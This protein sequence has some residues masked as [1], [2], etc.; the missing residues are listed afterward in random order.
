MKPLLD[1]LMNVVSDLGFSHLILSG[2]PVRGQKLDQLVELNG[3]PQEWYA[4]YL[5]RDYA[6]VDAVCAYSAVSP[7]P[8][9]WKDIPDTYSGTRESMNVANEASE[10]G[11]ISGF[12]VPFVSFRNW[13]SVVSFASSG[14]DCV[15][16]S[17]EKAQ[18]VTIATFAGAAAETIHCADGRD[19]PVELSDREREILLWQAEGKSSWEIGEILG[20]AEVTVKWYARRIRDKFGV[21]TTV[22]A[23]VEAIRR[24]AIRI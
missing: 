3:W 13:Q 17:R 18:V 1:D 6:S 11:I 2:V 8:F 19:D 22:Q 5:E 14:T 10:F 15:L 12:V 16:S 23:V 24:R 4:R 7:S 20:L 9:Y 21:A